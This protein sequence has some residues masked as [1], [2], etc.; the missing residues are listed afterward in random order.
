[1]GP[2]YVTDQGTPERTFKYRE[3]AQSILV[4]RGSAKYVRRGGGAYRTLKNEGPKY[5]RGQGTTDSHFK[6]VQAA[7]SI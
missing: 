1:V 3:A 2:K 6:Y 7:R 5:A 4:D